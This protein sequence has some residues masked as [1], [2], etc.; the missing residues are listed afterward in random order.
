MR[1]NGGPSCSHACQI[2]EAR[3]LREVKNFSLLPRITSDCHS[4]GAGGRLFVCQTCEGIQ[5]IPNAHW[6]KEIEDIYS[7]YETYYQSGGDEQIVFDHATGKPRRRS[8]VILERLVADKRL[9]ERGR[10]IDVGCGNGATLSAMSRVLTGWSFSGYELGGRSLPRLLR[11]PRFEKLYTGTLGAVDGRFDLVTMIHS[12]EH[13]PSP[14]KSLEN[15]LPIVGN[16]EIFIEAPNIEENPFDIL[17]ADHL[18]HFSPE[19]LSN[20]LRRAGFMPTVVAT[21]WIP[22]EISLLA[23]RNKK[24]TNCP[25]GLPKTR[26]IS[27]ALARMNA[28]V[29]WLQSTV[30]RISELVHEER[31][32]GIFG[33]SIA[34]T[35]L[36]GTLPGGIDFFVDEDPSR[37]GN[38]HMGRPIFSPSQVPLGARVYFALAPSLAGTV[39]TRLR[40]TRFEP[41]FPPPL[42]VS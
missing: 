1:N 40:S 9:G 42:A 37:I 39:A 38:E 31:S 27:G 2:C 28:S 21:D 4:F 35:W 13:F 15:L 34:A 5:K 32:L 29:D 12:L 33:T 23:N 7:N 8:D 20:L 11:I 10:A 17:I 19:T 3:D 22:K 6:L 30:D 41:V 16:G 26:I 18:M 14:R 36:A 24:R 25:E